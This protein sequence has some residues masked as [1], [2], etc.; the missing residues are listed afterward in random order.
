MFADRLLSPIRLVRLANFL[1]AAGTTLYL[2]LLGLILARVVAAL[3]GGEVTAIPWTAMDK[4]LDFVKQGFQK[5]GDKEA[6]KRVEEIVTLKEKAKALIEKGQK[7]TEALKALQ[8]AIKGLIDR[9]K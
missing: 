1:G 2:S 6:V 7:A 9:K 3:S 5:G 8:D 4:A